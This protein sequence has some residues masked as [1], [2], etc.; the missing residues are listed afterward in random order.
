[1]NLYYF[2]FSTLICIIYKTYKLHLL[3]FLYS[4]KSH[5][6]SFCVCARSIEYLLN[7]VFT[8]NVYS[9]DYG[10]ERRDT[11]FNNACKYQI[12]VVVITNYYYTWR[13]FFKKIITC[14]HSKS[15]V[16]QNFTV[17][18]ILLFV[19]F[20]AYKALSLVGV[21]NKSIYC[22]IFFLYISV[23]ASMPPL[24]QPRALQKI[25]QNRNRY[26]RLLS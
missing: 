23:L 20:F 6:V 15:Y 10:R 21:I 14:I 5:F 7:K 12:V 13:Y 26:L 19:I 18:E 8:C 16:C 22:V 24:H 4:S 3:F 2:I 17:L 9:V 11:F 25:L 1:M